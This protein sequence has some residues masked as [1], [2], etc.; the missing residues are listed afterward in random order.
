MREYKSEEIRNIAVVGHG[1]SGKTTLVDALAFVSGSSRRHGTVKD[2]T[3]LT[4]A[5]PEEAARG[6]S[7]SLGCAHAEWRDSKLNLLDTPGYADFAGDAIA[8]LVAADGALVT[9]S[10]TSG[11]E[12]GTERMFREAVRRKDPVLFVVSMMDKEH[13][14][15]DAAYASIRAKL[16]DKVVPVEIP[17]GSGAD[18]TGIINLFTKKAHIF[19]PGTKSDEYE[20]GPIPASE[21]ARFERYHAELVEAV[22]ATDDALLERFFA[23]EELPGDDEMRA[24]KEA[25]K[26]AELF[27]LLCCSSQLTYGVRTALDL[28]VQ[29]MPNAYEMEELHALHGAEGERT[30]EVHPRDDA[31]FTALVFKTTTEPHVGE[32]SY[33]RTFSGIVSNGADVY[34]ATRSAPE[35]LSHLAI[36]QGKERLEVTKLHPGDIGCV[37]KLRH[38]HTNDTLSTKEH[39]VRMPQIPFPDP[40][41]SFAIEAAARAD[42]EKLQLGLHRLHDED[43]TIQTH[44]EPETHETIIEGM[45]ERHLEV[46]LA[47]LER[48][49]GVKATLRAPRVPYRETLLGMAEGQGRHKKQTGGKGQFGDCWIRIKPLQRGNGY[50]FVDKISGGVIPRQYVPAVDKGVQEAAERGVLAGF[51]VVDFEVEVF[52]GSYHSVDSNEAS[53]KMAGILA[54]KTIAPKARP[55]LLEP[56]MDVEVFTPDAT[57]GDVLGDLSGRRGHILGTEPAADGSGSVVKAVVPM[58]ELHLYATRLQSLTHGYG[59]VKYRM[60]G[61]EQA[62]ADVVAKVTKEQHAE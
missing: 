50:R 29:L 32:V 46:A 47:R 53:F 23:G 45:G 31:P 20:V 42:E 1:A 8:G 16:T 9:V 22:A 19:K 15:F 41:V 62:P 35:K 58:A 39:P 2:G 34:N 56:L 55:V 11:V 21:Q 33:F 12:V 54:F 52:D 13:A 49:F 17:I 28:L 51:P 6:Y 37:A 43:P 3:T 27:P 26:Q 38:T 18:F 59:S 10:A 44:F 61:F 24:M 57:L 48:Q 4:D 60:H 25:M 36:P 5:S 30:V 14:D 7:I 40:L